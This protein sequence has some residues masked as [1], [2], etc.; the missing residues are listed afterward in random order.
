MSPYSGRRLIIAAIFIVISVIYL[1][2]IFYIQVMTDEYKLSANNNVLRYVTE[3]PA[4]GLVYDRKG[5]LMVYNEAVYD[6][7]II[8]KQVVAFDTTEFCELIGIT[9]DVFLE[10]YKK[11]RTY[12]AVK[13]TIFEKQLSSETYATLQEKL[14]KFK[15][16]FVQPRTLRKYPDRMGGHVLGYIGE[17]SDAMTAKNPYYRSGDYIGIS[18]IEQSY[19]EE[20]RGQR[21][22]KIIMVD[23]F[24]RPKGSFQEGKY[25]TVAVAGKNLI[26]S[27]DADLQAYGEQLMRNKMGSVVAIEPKTGEILAMVTAPN[28]D[29]NML[30]GRARTKNYVQLLLD[31]IKPLFNRAQMAYYPPGSTFKLVNALIA[32]Q[33]GVI[34]PSTRYPCSYR[35]GNHSV[36]CH[37]HPSPADLHAAVQYSCNP[38]FCHTFKN[39]LENPKYPTIQAGYEA[40]RENLFSFG[41]GRKLDVDMPNELRGMVPSVEYYDRFYG[42]GRWKAS[43]IF[44][45]GIGQGELGITPLQMANIVCIIANRGHFYVPHVI[46]KIGDNP[47]IDPR[48][49]IL[50]KTVVD[51]KYFDPIIEGMRD[52]VEAGTA[53]SSKLKFITVAGKTG[54]AQNPHGNDHSLF[55]AFAPIENPKIAIA[56]MVENAG[57]GG[58][59]AAPIATLMIEKFLNDSTARP[60]IE[61][62]IMD[63][64]LMPS[65]S[66]LPV[67]KL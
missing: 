35:V 27:L 55:L 30:V 39:L 22:L 57:F 41:I 11:A 21:G 33:E 10:K 28:Y 61:K 25:D 2:R 60:E 65:K 49:S 3:Y 46:K 64:N 16:F 17:V 34:T 54:T 51:S 59:W 56:V 12:S 15:G 14:Y 58:V 66:E 8:P 67:K 23:V 4:R 47:K 9:P 45:L 18:G 19:E 24:N 29:P 37:P 53:R 13:P 5:K 20:L 62:R 38:Y 1:I 63:A 44:S 31:P 32:Q 50:Q 42:K 40:W 52:V 6:L 48:F 43:T 36:N 7:M 26:S